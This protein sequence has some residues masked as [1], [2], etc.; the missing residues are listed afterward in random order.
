MSGFKS[1][2]LSAADAAGVIPFCR[3]LNRRKIRVLAYHGVDSLR[4]AVVNWDDLQVEPRVFRAHLGEL[5]RH[6]NVVPLRQVV[7]ALAGGE[8]LPDNAVA[9]TFDD[10]YRNNLTLAAP[11][12]KEYGFPATFFI[13]TGFLEGTTSP[14]W[15]RLREAF[16]QTTRPSV[17]LPGGGNAGLQTAEGRIHAAAAWENCLRVLPA[18]ERE[19]RLREVLSGCGSGR[20]PSMYPLMTRGEVRQLA[21][22]GFEIGPHTV[23][24]ISMGH[25]AGSV[26]EKEISDSIAA[27][28]EITGRPPDCYSYPYGAIPGGQQETL[29]TMKRCGITAAV[30]TSDG[31][32]CYGDDIFRLKR[33]NVAGHRGPAFSALIS[34]FTGWVRRPVAPHG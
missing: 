28:N 11:I 21:D 7:D 26:I 20:N 25:E 29:D 5:R 18:A 24:H 1:L 32:V 4:D 15:Y 14:W 30:S 8:R 6:Y 34:G 3:Y 23:T 22:M 27:V 13:T 33:L 10:G 31:L 17:A 19:E 12:L 2:L 16:A 9:I